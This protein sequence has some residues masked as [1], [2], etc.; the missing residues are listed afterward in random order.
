MSL[1]LQLRRFLTDG[2]NMRRRPLILPCALAACATLIGAVP[3]SAQQAQRSPT[4]TYVSPTR[5]KAGQILVLRGSGFSVRRA[6]NTI[7]FRGPSGRVLLIKPLSSSARRLTVRVPRAIDRLLSSTSGSKRPTR[8]TIRIVVR[9]KFGKWTTANRSPVVVPLSV[10]SA[11]LPQSGAPGAPGATQ[12][13]GTGD[14]Y[15]GDLL[16]NGLEKSIDTDPC[17]ADTDGDTVEDGFEYRSAR[18]LNQNAVPYPGKRPFP[19]PLDQSDAGDDYDGDGLSNGEEFVAWAHA[20]A[21]PTSSLLQSDTG[22]PRAPLFAGPYDDRPRFGGHDLPL[23]YSDGDQTTVDVKAIDGHPEYKSHLDLDG[24][25]RLTDDERDVDG[26]GLGNYSEIRGLMNPG[27]YPAGEDCGYEYVPTLP[28]PF[29]QPNYL[30]WDADGDGVW[31]GNDDQDSDDV[32]NVDEVQ[33]PYSPCTPES[34]ALPVDGAQD[35]LPARRSPY[36][37]CLPYSSRTCSL[38]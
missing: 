9:K 6:S 3:A 12:P 37:P 21:N 15:D 16:P 36:N 28:R 38:N 31:D 13:C 1:A 34:P 8:V 20:P 32:S 19:N 27:F 33:P 29:Q 35:G 14:D 4:V 18:D 2:G 10:P 26:D 30:T 17:M 5:V 25:G 11:F 7:I 23:N 24:D 22:D